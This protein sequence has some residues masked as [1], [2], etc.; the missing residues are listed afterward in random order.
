MKFFWIIWSLN[1]N[2]NRTIGPQAIPILAENARDANDRFRAMMRGNDSH[3]SDRAV[4]YISETEPA[5]FYA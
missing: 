2:G 1:T 4:F 3:F 5:I